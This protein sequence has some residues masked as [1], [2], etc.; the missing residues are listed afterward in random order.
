MECGIKFESLHDARNLQLQYS[1]EDRTVGA[2][3]VTATKIVHSELI[4]DTEPSDWG[5]RDFIIVINRHLIVM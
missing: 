3:S 1:A 2:D 4:S 5:N